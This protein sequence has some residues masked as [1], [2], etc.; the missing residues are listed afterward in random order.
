MKR[1]VNLILL[2]PPGAGKGTQ[3]KRL[4]EKYPLEHLSSGDMLRA[5]RAAKSELG[6][7]VTSFM[8]SGKLV[9]D[10]LVTE[11]VISRIRQELSHGKKGVLLDGFPRTLG[12]AK[13]LEKAFSGMGAK[14]DAVIDLMLVSE[15]IVDRMSGRRSC[16]KCGRVYHVSANPAKDGQSCDDCHVPLDQRVDDKEEVVRNRLTVYSDQTLPLEEYYKKAGL[17]KPVDASREIDTVWL[18]IE[19]IVDAL[20]EK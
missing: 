10:E 20:V 7:K 11:V 19:K 8:D 3:A 15:L 13:D 16:P 18:Q 6:Q 1:I 2:G 4:A 14:I 5:E 17:L 9:P 12:Q